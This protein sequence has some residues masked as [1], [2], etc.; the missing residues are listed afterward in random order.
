MITSKAGHDKELNKKFN[1]EVNKY[2]EMAKKLRNT[3]I[4][5]DHDHEDAA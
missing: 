1:E 3:I 4:Y 5:M 2:H